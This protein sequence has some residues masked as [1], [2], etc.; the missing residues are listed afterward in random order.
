M[1]VDYLTDWYGLPSPVG[2]TLAGRGAV[3]RLWRLD[4]GDISYAVKESRRPADEDAVAFQVACGRHAAAHGVRVPDSLPGRDGR[5]VM[6]VPDRYGGGWVRVFEWVSGTAVDL[7]DPG[8]ATEVGELLGRLHAGALPAVGAVD[9]WYETVPDPG[10]WS[11][12]LKSAPDE[13]WPGRLADRLPLIR[14]LSELVTPA[15]PDQLLT[16]HR[17]LHPDNV[18]RDA[19]GDLIVLDWDDVGP[20]A[21]ARE[22]AR[23]LLNWQVDAGALVAGYRAAGGTARLAEPGVF[24]MAIACQLNFLHRQVR[25]ASD[26]S[27]VD[28][29]RRYAVR[30]ILESLA[31]LPTPEHLA[32][33]IDGTLNA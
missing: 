33:L 28:D 3:G 7:T 27:T 32:D 14:R 16:C 1:F 11:A 9:P 12:L 19:G 5:Y 13:A 25:I 4:L 24:T 8:L 26:P 10:S 29:D 30:E 20:A 22:L 23:A 31:M 6:A 2:M 15:P 18:L 21:P 17:D